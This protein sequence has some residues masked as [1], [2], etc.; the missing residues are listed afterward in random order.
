MGKLEELLFG[1]NIGEWNITE[2][3]LLLKICYRE[4]VSYNDAISR[5]AFC[6]RLYELVRN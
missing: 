3:S 4:A 6:G 5:R 2:D 1:K